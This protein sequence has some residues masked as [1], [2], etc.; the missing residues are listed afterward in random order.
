[1]GSFLHDY[2]IKFVVFERAARALTL[3]FFQFDNRCKWVKEGCINLKKLVIKN[4]EC[5]M[6]G[7]VK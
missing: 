3:R 2:N 4:P 7:I 1:M 6:L 5:T